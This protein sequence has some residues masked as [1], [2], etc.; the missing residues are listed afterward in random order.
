MQAAELILIVKNNLPALPVLR[1]QNWFMR[2]ARTNYD[3]KIV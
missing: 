1:K 2:I 3:K